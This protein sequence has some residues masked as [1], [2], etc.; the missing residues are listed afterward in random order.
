MPKRKSCTNSAAVK[1]TRESTNTSIKCSTKRGRSSGWS[2]SETRNIQ[3]TPAG[4]WRV[5]N[6]RPGLD[7]KWLPGLFDS[8]EEAKIKRQE[9][10]ALAEPVYNEEDDL[11]QQC[12]PVKS[13]SSIIMNSV[14]N[15]EE[16]SSICVQQVDLCIQSEIR[17]DKDD[18]HES[19]SNK[20][21]VVVVVLDEAKADTVM[22]QETLPQTKQSDA[23][24][25]VDVAALAAT[26]KNIVSAAA[27]IDS[28]INLLYFMSDPAETI[29]GMISFTKAAWQQLLGLTIKQFNIGTGFPYK[30]VLPDSIPETLGS[31]FCAQLQT[32][33]NAIFFHRLSYTGVNEIVI[34]GFNQLH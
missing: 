13:S 4:K 18:H 24:L 5:R 30:I 8:L 34:Y 6:G 32:V 29:K 23:A 33:Y 1:S 16:Q 25:A 3:Q 20:Q 14:E 15:V 28:R 31:A 12:D 26:E 22:S 10:A 11:V 7:R 2:K 21:E 19:K 17:P 27:S 9:N